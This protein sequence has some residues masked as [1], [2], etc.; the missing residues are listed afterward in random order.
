MLCSSLIDL[1]KYSPALSYLQDLLTFF[2][3]LPWET[4]D[5]LHNFYPT[6]RAIA[7]TAVERIDSLPYRPDDHYWTSKDSSLLCSETESKG[8]GG[9]LPRVDTYLHE[10]DL[11]RVPRG[12][13]RYSRVV[14][15]FPRDDRRLR[16]RF[17]CC[18]TLYR[19]DCR[20]NRSWQTKRRAPCLVDRG[21]ES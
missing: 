5:D 15:R 1:C 14:W 21:I 10:V 7:N 8:H 20:Q 6:E 13:V 16:A 4:Y 9:V 2:P 19:N 11:Y 17:A 3:G 12:S 18:G